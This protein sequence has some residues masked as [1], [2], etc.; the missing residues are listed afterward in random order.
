[1]GHFWPVF[2][3]I[4]GGLAFLSAVTNLSQTVAKSQTKQ[5]K[6]WNAPSLFLRQFQCRN[7]KVPFLYRSCKTV[8]I[9]NFPVF[10]IIILICNTKSCPENCWWNGVSIWKCWNGL[11]NH[12]R[13]DNSC[14]IRSD[15]DHSGLPLKD[16]ISNFLGNIFSAKS[17]PN[18]FVRSSTCQP[19]KILCC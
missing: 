18:L 17:F 10:I 9:G 19:I 13:E 6:L 15:M 5:I 3:W 8:R 11:K 4:E 7:I 2:D 12:H 14:L 1:M 16:Q